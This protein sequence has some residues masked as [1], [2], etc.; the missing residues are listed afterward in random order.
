MFHISPYDLDSI[1]IDK[2]MTD[3]YGKIG[4]RVVSGGDL[5]KV[6]PVNGSVGK[7]NPK[8]YSDLT[9][10]PI[11]VVEAWG[12]GYHL[13]SAL[14]YISRAGNKEGESKHDDL[15]KAIWFLERAISL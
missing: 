12:L 14:K 2:L 7:I 6:N 3:K 5:S 8:H 1:S 13:G 9:P 10:Q 4:N 11:E 15:K